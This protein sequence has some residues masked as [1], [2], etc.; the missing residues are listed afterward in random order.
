[1][2]NSKEEILLK[3]QQ[4]YNLGLEAEQLAV[5]FLVCHGYAIKERR[6]KPSPKSKGEIDIIAAVDNIIVFTEV[7]A[8]SNGMYE[9]IEAVDKKKMR[10]ITYGADMYLRQQTA[11]YEYRYDIIAIDMTKNPPEIDHIKDAFLS[12]MFTK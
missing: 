5:D 10:Y 1:M 9:A 6:W 7:K 3:R 11:L 2:H 8:R 4:A 12:P